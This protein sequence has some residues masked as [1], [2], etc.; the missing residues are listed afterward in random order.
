MIKK[1]V[2]IL[3]VALPFFSSAQNDSIPSGEFG[4]D[5]C[6]TDSKGQ[7]Q[8]YW[9]RVYESGNLYYTGQFKDGKPYGEFS[10]FYDSGELMAINQHLNDELVEN[11]SYRREGTV[12]SKGNY[13]NQKKHGEWLY[14]DDKGVVRALETY[15]NDVLDGKFVVYYYNGQVSEETTFS[16]GKREGICREY[17][18]TGELKSERTFSAGVENG[19]ILAYDA[20]NVLLYK[21][22]M[23][24]GKAVG[25]WH[26]YLPNGKVE[27]RL[28][29]DDFGKELVRKMEN[30][31]EETFYDSG[32]PKTYYEYKNG[33]KHGIFEEY[34]NKGDFVR[35]EVIPTE[36]GQPL[37]WVE[38]LENTQLKVEGQYRMGK[39]HGEIIY[40]N[41]DGTISKTEVYEHGVLIPE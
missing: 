13:K 19:E 16:L 14:Y 4:V 27:F 11:T 1:I 20:P 10:Y 36:Q 37:E 3:C 40:Y 6:V 32:I 34:Y 8:G 26:Y 12:I 33:M 5:Y 39:L 30:G 29:Y 35:K 23:K 38:S 9:I 2:G 17:F 25:E 7:K 15:E 28:L 31:E 22:Q 18:L 21:G 41:E 24:N